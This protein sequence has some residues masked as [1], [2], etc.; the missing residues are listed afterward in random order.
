MFP[1]LSHR[2]RRSTFLLLL[3]FALAA[4]SIAPVPARA[5]QSTIDADLLDQCRERSWQLY[6]VDIGGLQ[7]EALWRAPRGA[8]NGGAIIVLHGGGG[9]AA[10]FCAG[11]ELVRPQIE[12]A[13]LALGSGYAVIALEATND[14]VTDASGNV[15]GKRFDF[16]VQERPNLDL[17]FIAHILREMIPAQRPAGSS[18][19]VFLT[20]LS[21]GGYMTITAA[22]AFADEL[23][24]F[25]PIA[26]GDPNQTQQLCDE[27]LSPRQSAKGI[28]VDLHSQRNITSRDACGATGPVPP[29]ARTSRAI[30]FRQFHYRNDA[31]VDISCMHKA[32]RALI[33]AGF[34]GEEPYI[35][36]RGLVRQV[37][38]HLWRSDY[39]APL[40]DFFNRHQD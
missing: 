18:E 25:A 36:P 33:D 23:S 17:P 15:C 9:S 21:T 37:R 38:F 3:A 30:A 12:F 5:A 22:R 24:G 26:A 32:T 13:D 1:S 16:S 7:R 14:L 35:N 10:H 29:V 2:P 28:L 11:P 4:L 27:T 39:N 31:I 8:W 40:I 34:W 20:G 19:A 6:T